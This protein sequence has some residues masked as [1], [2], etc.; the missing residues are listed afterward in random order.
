[1]CDIRLTLNEKVNVNNLMRRFVLSKK[2][3]KTYLS[4]VLRFV[5]KCG[6]KF[7]SYIDDLSTNDNLS[8]FL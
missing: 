6:V 8:S 2:S 4:N 7:S 3:E 5:I 1:M